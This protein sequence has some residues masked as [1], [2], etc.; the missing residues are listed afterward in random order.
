MTLEPLLLIRLLLVILTVHRLAQFLSYDEGPLH[1][2]QLVRI[3][4]GAYDLAQ[5]GQPR[6]ALGRLILCPYCLGVW[7]AIPSVVIVL[8][9]SLPTDVLLLWLGIAGAQS[10]LHDHSR[11][12]EV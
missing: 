10:V 4:L 3:A 5:T 11:R 1:L 12:G 8:R 9:P 6:S 2:A 7:L